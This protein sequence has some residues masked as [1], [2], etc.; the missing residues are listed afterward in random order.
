[1]PPAPLFSAVRTARSSPVPQPA[2]GPPALPAPRAAARSGSPRGRPTVRAHHVPPERGTALILSTVSG[3]Q[4]LPGCCGQQCFLALTRC[5]WLSVTILKAIRAAW[6]VRFVSLGSSGRAAQELSHLCHCSSHPP[7]CGRR[8]RAPGNPA[9]GEGQISTGLPRTAL[10]RGAGRAPISQLERYAAVS[11]AAKDALAAARQA[12][13]APGPTGKAPRGRLGPPPPPLPSA[14]RSCRRGAQPCRTPQPTPSIPQRV[15][16][17]P[18]PS[19]PAPSA[20]VWSTARRDPKENSAREGGGQQRLRQ[21]SRGRRAL[22]CPGVTGKELLP[23]R[24]PGAPAQSSRQAPRTAHQAESA[25]IKN[26]PARPSPSPL[27]AAP[28]GW[29]VEE[30]GCNRKSPCGSIQSK[31]N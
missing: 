30:R 24:Q 23:P 9:G 5:L 3:G 7:W 6:A 21:P 20:A 28:L 8:R 12:G 2:G 29:Q 1:M 22:C 26:P 15:P 14:P 13:R 27:P 10:G 19:A 31:K 11:R 25:G 18:L 4:R 16:I 17:L